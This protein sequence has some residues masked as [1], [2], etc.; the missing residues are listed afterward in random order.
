MFKNIRRLEDGSFII[1]KN[2]YDYHVYNGGNYLEEYNQLTQY[3]AEN[4]NAVTDYK[5]D[6]YEP[7]KEELAEQIRAKRDSLLTQADVLLL[8]YQEQV[9]LGVINADDDYRLSLLQ[10]KENLRNVPEQEG[11]PDNVVFPELPE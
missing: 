2:G 10:Y 4:P 6:K 8:K 11:F 3:I 9:E 5:I 7:S 1:E